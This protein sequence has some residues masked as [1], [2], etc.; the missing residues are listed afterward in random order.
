[1]LNRLLNFWNK[2]NKQQKNSLCLS[3]V[4]AGRS[5]GIDRLDNEIPK[6]SPPIYKTCKTLMHTTLKSFIWMILQQMFTWPEPIFTRTL[7]F[8]WVEFPSVISI[9]VVINQENHPTQSHQLFHTLFPE[10]IHHF[11]QNLGKVNNFFSIIVH[12]AQDKDV[13]DEKIEMMGNLKKFYCK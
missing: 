12:F 1:M 2:A 7:L 10:Y 6:L 11:F 5:N 4:L 8:L 3:S 13:F 9:S